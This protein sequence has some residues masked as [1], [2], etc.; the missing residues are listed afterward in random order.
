L[1]RLRLRFDELRTIFRTLLSEF[2]QPLAP[3]VRVPEDLL[4][5]RNMLATRAEAWKQQWLDEGQRKGESGP[6]LRQLE[7]RFGTLPAEVR[8]R[9]TS[10]GTDN[11][12]RWSLRVIG[13]SSLEEIF[14]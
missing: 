12:E 8:E 2:I 6:L 3:G 5:V 4:E 7:H 10:A 13:A 14:A 1:A 9:I 11:L